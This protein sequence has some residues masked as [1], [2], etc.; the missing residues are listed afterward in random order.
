MVYFR[1]VCCL[2]G[3]K[4]GA[5]FVSAGV[6]GLG[7]TAVTLSTEA[8]GAAGHALSVNVDV[9]CTGKGAAMP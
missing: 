4:G 9:H 2:N 3:P 7:L 6:I 8:V 5:T 1:I